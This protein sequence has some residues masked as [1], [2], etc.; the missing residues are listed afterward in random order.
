MKKLSIALV[1]AALVAL[2]AAT[3]SAD[4]W[5]GTEYDFVDLI[6]YWTLDRQPAGATQQFGEVDSVLIGQN[7]PLSY[8]HT[9]TGFVIP[10]E[11]LVTEAW[12]ELDFTND[13]TDES[14]QIPFTNIYLYDFREYVQVGF[15]GNVWHDLG[16][17]DDGYYP[18]DLEVIVGVE[19][20]N[21]DGT[22]NVTINVSNP[23]CTA[24]AWL[25]HSVLYG[26]VS[27][28][29]VPGAVLLGVLGLSAAGIKLRK[30]RAA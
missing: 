4:V 25:D 26:N 3:A 6:D 21:L 10:D 19:L 1:V 23:G 15:D 29:P 18:M 30:N 12:L 28:V 14:L 22:L 7:L 2:T 16:E 20:L 27:V 5:R 13:T 9:I 24:T 8:T 11:Y 17:V